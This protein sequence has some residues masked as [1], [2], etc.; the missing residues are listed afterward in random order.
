[1]GLPEG[2]D[3]SKIHARFTDG[4]LEVKVEGAAAVQ[5][6]KRMQIEGGESATNQSPDGGT[7]SS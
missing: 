5:E 1:M 7:S 6:P 3:A 4:V 2:V